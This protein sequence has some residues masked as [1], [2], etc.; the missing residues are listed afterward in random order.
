MKGV[1]FLELIWGFSY[2]VSDIS[3]TK[4][5]SISFFRSDFWAMRIKKS[6]FILENVVTSNLRVYKFFHLVA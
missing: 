1:C 3:V 5:G 6:C 2:L 4:I